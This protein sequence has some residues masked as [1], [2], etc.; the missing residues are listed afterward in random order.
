MGER[1]REVREFVEDA[2]GPEGLARSVVVAATSDAPAL[3]RAR[4]AH[5]ATAIAEWFADRGA[6]VVLLL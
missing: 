1:G 2:L 3:V 5:V 4:A 6:R